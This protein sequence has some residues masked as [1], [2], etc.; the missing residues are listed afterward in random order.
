METAEG[1]AFITARGA[2]GTANAMG[3]RRITEHWVRHSIGIPDPEL[4]F[5]KPSEK[6]IIA[7]MLGATEMWED[8]PETVLQLANAGIRTHMP[9]YGYNRHIAHPLVLPVPWNRNADPSDAGAV[10]VA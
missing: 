5:V 3:T 4:Y 7:R 8:H 9:L 2:E 10:A 6:V 1:F